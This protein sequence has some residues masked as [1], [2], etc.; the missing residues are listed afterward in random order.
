MKKQRN[1]SQLNSQESSPERTMKQTSLVWQTLISKR[2]KIKIL[3]E[4]KKADRNTG[5]YKKLETIKN[6]QEKLE[7]WFAVR[8]T[9]LKA[10]KIR[11]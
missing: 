7:N 11:Q 4:L 1:Y 2:K 3:K 8:K 5:Y 6:K 10:M 9:E